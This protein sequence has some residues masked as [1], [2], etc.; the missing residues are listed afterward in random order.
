MLTI[1]NLA[2]RYGKLPSQVL[3]EATTFDLAVL[4]I[5]AKWERYQHDKANGKLKPA[6]ADLSQDEMLAM[7]QRVREQNK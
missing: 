7:L 6:G 1:D 5:S 3:A 4:D 2:Y